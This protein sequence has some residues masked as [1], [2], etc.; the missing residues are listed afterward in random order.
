MVGWHRTLCLIQPIP[1]TQDCC[2]LAFSIHYSIKI[3]FSLL[4]V[5]NPSEIPQLKE[6]AQGFYAKRR[7]IYPR[8]SPR[9]LFFKLKTLSIIVLLGMYYIIPWLNWGGRQAVLFDLPGRKFYIFGLVFWPQDL[10]YLAF[11][12]II[13]AITL[14]FFTTLAGR[15]WCG[16]AC[17]QTVWTDVF[18]R[19]ERWVEGDR[20]QQ[21]K[22]DRAPISWYK[23]RIKA[24]KHLIWIIFS[25]Y[26]GLTFLGYFTP[27]RELTVSL[28]PY[29]LSGWE[30]FWFLFYSFATYG[31]AGA[32]R[33]QICVYMCP[34]ARFQSAMFDKDT[35]IIAYDEK[36]GEPRG[37][38]KRSEVGSKNQKLGDCVNCTLCVQVCPAGID[39]R[40]GLQYQCISCSYCIDACDDIM[41]KMNYP[42]GLIR[43]T[44]EHRLSGHTTHVLRPRVFIYGSIILGIFMG[45]GYAISQRELVQLDVIRDRT[46]LY[47]ETTQGFIENV[48][49]LRIMN[50]D[51]KPHTYGITATGLEGLEL[52]QEDPNIHTQPGSVSEATVRLVVDPK[53]IS[54]LSS[55]VTFKLTAQ[56]DPNM[57]TIE[58]ARFLGPIPK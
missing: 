39:I 36:R 21:I 52:L 45:I 13:A 44:T 51:Q 30:T 4:T 34:Y 20:S 5:M 17:P 50:L 47:R 57:T 31:N 38:R 53:K 25:L 33:E 16:F 8:Q 27:I 41:E 54:R 46:S 48:Y 29:H 7:K 1:M 19:M 12:L 15:L 55:K 3:L 28:Y 2:F 14:F 43:Y 40:N 56:D 37:A 26:T 24:T 58:E 22:L 10:I 42:K 35:L 9:K 49:S 11:L 23:F 18:I 6:E 32:L